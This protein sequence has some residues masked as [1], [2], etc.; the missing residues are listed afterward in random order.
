M[1]EVKKESAAEKSPSSFG[2]WVSTL[3]FVAFLLWVWD[4]FWTT[5]ISILNEFQTK[6]FPEKHLRENLKS[7]TQSKNL[8]LIQDASSYKASLDQSQRNLE[9]ACRYIESSRM[10]ISNLQGSMTA[11]Q[12]LINARC[13]SK[14]CESLLSPNK[15]KRTT[16]CE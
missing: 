16:F 1:E 11:D 12:L 6:Y 13:T 8:A 10:L 5:N 3:I 7:Q 2:S 14:E 15:D 4:G 9:V